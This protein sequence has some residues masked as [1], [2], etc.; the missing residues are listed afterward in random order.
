MLTGLDK[1]DVC[2]CGSQKEY[3]KCHADFDERVARY[4]KRGHLVPSRQMIKNPLQIAAIRESGKV[5]TAVLDTVAEYVRAGITT[6][7]IDRLVY[8]KAVELGGVPAQLGYKGFPKSVCTSLNNQVCHGIPSPR[9]VLYDGDIINVDVSTIYKDYFSDSSRMFCVGKATKEARRLVRVGQECVVLGLKQVRPWGFLG[10]LGQ[11]IQEHAVKHGYSVVKKIGG[12]GIG[13][14]FHEPPWIGY[15]G[16]AN[17][18]MLLAPGMIFTIE[19]IINAGKAS[20]YLDKNGWTYYTEDDSL[21]VQW[22]V[23]MLVT[24]DGYEVMAY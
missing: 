10:D 18:G 16:K 8:Q 14:R 15:E 4:K 21:S 24:E 5:N 13:L 17:T 20:I 9:T 3:K 23:M 22:E 1:N 12:H 2:W 6:E 11:V 19:P 7:E